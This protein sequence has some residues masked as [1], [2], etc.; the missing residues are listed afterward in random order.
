M[1]KLRKAL[2]GV[3]N[4]LAGG[5][6]AV[7]VILTTYQVV[8]RYIFNSPSTWSEELVGY[9]FGWSTMLGA[10]I[11]SG[12][13]GHM[14]IPILVDHFQPGMRKAFHILWEVVAFVFS[15][16]IL[17]FGGWQ[18]SNLAMG[19]Q[20]SS[21]GVAVGVF[22]WVMPLC[23]VVI[24]LYSVLNIIGIANGTISLDVSDEATEAVAKVEAEKAATAANA[25]NA[26]KEG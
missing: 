25:A 22:Y 2:N 9:L 4:V 5:S 26:K 11:V 1:E 14:N 20:T 15:A 17:V 8:A 18:V 3:L 23:G 21:L 19:Q 10:T 24:L 7:M 13:R 16:T 6:M 12:E